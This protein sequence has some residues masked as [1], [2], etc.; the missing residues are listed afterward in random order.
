MN[1]NKT[2]II[3]LHEIYGVNNFILDVCQQYHLEGHDVFCPNLL[4]IE[5]AFSY[6][7]ESEAYSSF[8]DTVGFDAFEKINLIASDLKMTYSK[9]FLIGFSVG[10]TIGWR[11]SESAIYDGVICCYGSRI[12]DYL[13]VQPQCPMLL[14]FAKYDSFDVE[15]IKVK[16]QNRDNVAVE[17]SEASHGFID[18]FSKNY[19][20]SEAKVFEQLRKAFLAD[21]TK[22]HFHRTESL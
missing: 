22:K 11:C 19:N 20:R 17:I 8:L 7:E 18:V 5:G 15:A 13:T 14:V 4:S 10:A 3:V 1:D 6:L 9:V 2:A 16:L 12:R 21:Y